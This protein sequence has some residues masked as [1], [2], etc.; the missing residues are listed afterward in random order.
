[1]SAQTSDPIVS[2]HQVVA[3][4]A[5]SAGAAG[6]TSSFGV[7]GTLI[8]AALTAMIITGGSAILK[9]Y[10]ENAT[11]TVK[12]MPSV[13]RS[14]ANRHKAG[15]TPEAPRTLPDNPGLRD[16]FMGR[17]RASLGWFSR[18]PSGR[19]RSILVKGLIAALVA[20]VIGMGVVTA[21]EKGLIGNSLSCGFWGECYGGATPGYNGAATSTSGV[22]STVGQITGGGDAAE[23]AT[24]SVADE[25]DTPSQG[26]ETPSVPGSGAS[27]EEQPVPEG[28]TPAPVPEEA[29]AEPVPGEEAPAEPVV[30]EEPAVPE[31]P[32]SGTED[33]AQEAPVQ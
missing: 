20:F 26:T 14:R 31:T 12:K 23:E 28:G 19:R 30:P 6:V 7:A 24:P 33:P 25:Q 21:T 32:P 8:G 10:L 15:R 5:A 13:F 29:P 27:E 2:P 1:M 22:T 16:N 18:L 9:A 11:G 4:G 17:L 3:A